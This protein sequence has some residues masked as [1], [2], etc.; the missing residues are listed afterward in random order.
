[1]RFDHDRI[2]PETFS[3]IKESGMKYEEMSTEFRRMSNGVTNHSFNNKMIL[4][5]TFSSF[6]NTTL[7][8]FAKITFSNLSSTEP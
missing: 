6:R 1:M 3:V 7:S 8:M 4:L 2:L 5:N